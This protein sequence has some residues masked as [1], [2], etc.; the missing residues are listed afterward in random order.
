[1]CERIAFE[2]ALYDLLLD[3]RLIAITLGTEFADHIQH[4]FSRM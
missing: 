3:T 4:V 1:M 2:K